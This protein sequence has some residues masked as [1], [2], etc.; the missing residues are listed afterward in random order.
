M[1]M[2]NIDAELASNYISVMLKNARIQKH[3]TQK[4]AAE[5][6]G[7]SESTISAIE[8]CNS[9]SSPTLRSLIKYTEALE[10]KINIEV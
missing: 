7:L 9:S 2:N 5:L 10:V 3:I 8:N 4:Q 1:K 6:S